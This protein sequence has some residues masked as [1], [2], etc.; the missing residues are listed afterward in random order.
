MVFRNGGPLRAYEKWTYRGN[1]RE[2]VSFYKYI[3]DFLTPKLSWTKTKDILA[4]QASKAVVNIFKYQ[5]EYGYFYANEALTLF[6]SIAVPMLCY[7]A[8]VWGYQ[9]SRVY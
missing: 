1:T 2:V 5:K 3:G 4:K 8:E 6:D 7:S 9:Y